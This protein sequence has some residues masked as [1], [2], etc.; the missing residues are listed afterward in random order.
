MFGFNGDDIID[1]AVGED[2]KRTSSEEIEVYL[3][4]LMSK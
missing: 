4:S 2:A 1:G 3:D